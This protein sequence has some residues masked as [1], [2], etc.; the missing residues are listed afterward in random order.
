MAERLADEQANVSIFA[1]GVGRGVEKTE[2]ERI[3]AVCGADKV[4]D[5]A[6][7]CT[8][9]VSTASLVGTMGEETLLRQPEVVGGT[10]HFPHQGPHVCRALQGLA[11]ALALIV[12]GRLS[13][14]MQSAA[15][16]ADLSV[17]CQVS[18]RYIPLC[19]LDEAPW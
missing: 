10:G 19:T 8:V 1:M 14:W 12:C 13:C 16:L 15:G 6:G 18:T 17:C 2:L 5:L 9:Y 11:P 4:R 3:I 7:S